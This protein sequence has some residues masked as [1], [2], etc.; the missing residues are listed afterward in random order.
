MAALAH[1]LLSLLGRA[2]EETGLDRPLKVNTAK[3]RTHS[4]L[5]QGWSYFGMIPTMKEERLRPLIK[6][7]AELLELEPTLDLLQTSK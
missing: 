1:E 4:L 5:T 6:H 2:V 7:F 3:K